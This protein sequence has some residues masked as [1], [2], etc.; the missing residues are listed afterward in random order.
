M[1][2]CMSLSHD[3]FAITFPDNLIGFFE[4]FW[5]TCTHERRRLLLCEQAYPTVS[6]CSL[7]DAI[8]GLSSNSNL[9]SLE[10]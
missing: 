1:V 8:Y 5:H 4:H 2:C 7:N 10:L 6:H 3:T 9:L